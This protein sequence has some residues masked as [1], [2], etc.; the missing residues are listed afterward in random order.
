M[1]SE[2]KKLPLET[3]SGEFKKGAFIMDKWN[4]NIKRNWKH[5]AGV[6]AGVLFLFICIFSPAY[7]AGLLKPINGDSNSVHIRSHNVDVTINNGFARTEVDQVFFNEADYDL[8][9][10]Y[11]FPLPRQASLSEVSLWIDGK[12]VIGEVVEKERA[13][14]IYENQKT[15]GNETALAEKDDF[16]V[17]NIHVGNIRANSETRIRCVYY[18][19]LEID[20]NIGRY[21]YPLAEGNVDE[22]RIAFW[23]VDNAVH[24]TFNFD[25]ELKSAFPVIDVRM[26]G[27]EGQAV[28]QKVQGDGDNTSTGDIYQAKLESAE[29]ANLSKDVIFYYRLDD[30]VPARV[31]LIP[32]RESPEQQG[33]FMAVVTPAASLQRIQEGVDWTFV[34]DVSGSMN[35]G[36][37]QKL[38]DAVTRVLGKLTPNDRFHIVTFNNKVRE[39][40]NGYIQATEANI[41][42]NIHKVQGIQAGGGTA[43]F[44]GLKRAYK[45]LHDDRTSS[46]ILITD[47]VCNVGPTQHAD[48]LDLI[49]QRDVRLFTFVIGNSANRPLMEKLAKE[50]GGFSMNISESD[51]IVGRL[52]QAKAKLLHECLYDVELK[53]HGKKVKSL[54]PDRLG[55]LY[56]GQQLIVFGRYDGSGDVNLELKARISGQEQTWQ[57]N[58]MFPE[59]DRENPEIERLWALSMIEDSMETIREKGENES[60]RQDVID[61]GVEYSFVTDYTSMVVFREDEMESEQIQRRNAGRVERE[62]K[63]QQARSTAPV[64]NYRVDNL[65]NNQGAFQGSPSPGIGS[66]PVGPLFGLIILWF[67]RRKKA[68]S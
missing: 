30:S 67:S 65:N 48:F 62:R 7:G 3:L 44:E 41:Q 58:A 68:Q 63:A 54:T 47:G 55:N 43:L 64:K 59:V 56:K 37:I 13:R 45:R 2:Q 66:G 52:I 26:P 42:S 8:E 19:P 1:K 24:G 57:C 31:E 15:R 12:E 21:V 38:T 4:K 14:E 25:L 5:R 29:G 61:L 36:K 28:I 51:D 39:L 50:S 34:L 33:T 16:K 60:L 23:T 11:T 20:L 9:A 53:F 49:Q 18:Q 10:T 6:A 17:F 35:G 32:Y 22:E 27:L 46:L 40:T